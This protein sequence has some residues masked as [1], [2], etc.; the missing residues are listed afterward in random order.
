[1]S[2]KSIASSRQKLLRLM[3]MTCEYLSKYSICEHSLTKP[4]AVRYGKKHWPNE[5]NSKVQYNSFARKHEAKA[6][7]KKSR[8]PQQ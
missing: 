2:Q 4:I 7:R 5:T 1:M 3:K 6:L 8:R